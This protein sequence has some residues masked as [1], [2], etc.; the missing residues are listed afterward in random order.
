MTSHLPS[1]SSMLCSQCMKHTSFDHL[2]IHD[3]LKHWD[4]CECVL[5][6]MCDPHISHMNH[7]HHQCNT[8]LSTSHIHSHHHCIQHN[9]MS[10][11]MCCSQGNIHQ[12]NMKHNLHSHHS[13]DHCF[14]SHIL[15]L[16]PLTHICNIPSR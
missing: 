16:P 1:H 3:N 15:P 8:L 6:N 12:M 13:C 11:G 10:Q 9:V 5:D 2:N 4:D 7:H 14:M